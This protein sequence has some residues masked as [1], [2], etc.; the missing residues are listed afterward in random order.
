MCW[1]SNL[2][3]VTS[4]LPRY[5]STAVDRDDASVRASCV[6]FLSLTTPLALFGFCSCLGGG[7]AGSFAIFDGAIFLCER[8]FREQIRRVGDSP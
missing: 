3:Q 1:C 5:T 7:E 6:C 8:G 4:L 2:L